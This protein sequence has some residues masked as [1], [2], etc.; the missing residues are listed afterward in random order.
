[1]THTHS[2]F[3][4]ERKFD[5]FLFSPIGEENNGM[6]LSV[7]SALARRNVDPWQEAARL[8]RLPRDVATEELCAVIAE[9][10]PGMPS[11]ASPRVIAERLIAPLPFY[12]GS[13]GS[14]A[15]SALGKVTLTRRE[16]VS[17]AVVL[18]CLLAWMVFTEIAQQSVRV[19][20]VLAPISTAVGS[21]APMPSAIG[22]PANPPSFEA[23]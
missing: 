7:I 11:R 9:L 10:P 2:L 1:M 20:P 4:F 21:P 6:V 15:K 5:E 3:L 17:T 16:I 8:S 12:V 18:F 19:S 22:L 23:R 13:A 14:S